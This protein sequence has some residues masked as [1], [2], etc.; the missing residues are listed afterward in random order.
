LTTQVSTENFAANTIVTYSEWSNSLVPKISNVSIAN[1]SYSL[2]DDTAISTNGGY[3]VITGTGF[4]DGATVIINEVTATAVSYINATRLNVQLPAKSAATYDVYVVNPDGATAIG[5]NKI[6]YSAS[7]VWVTDTTLTGQSVDTAFNITFNA[8]GAASY[9]NTTALPAGTT[10]L[11]NGYFYGTV[12]GIVEETTYNF[13]IR[14]TD[15]ENQDSDKNFS[16]TVSVVSVPTSVEYLVVAGGGGGGGAHINQAG[17]AGGG[18]GGYR[19]GTLSIS[20]STPYTVTIGAGGAGGTAT[21]SSSTS[22][23]QGQ[24]SVFSTIT[25]AGGGYGAGG[26]SLGTAGGSGGSGGGGKY[27]SGAAG[28]GNVPSTSPPQGNNGG[29]YATGAPYA[30]GGGGGIGAA[31]SG[32]QGGVGLNWNSLGTYYAGGGSGGSNNET[33]GGLG[34]GGT[35]GGYLQNSGNGATAGGTNTGGGGGGGAN[36]DYPGG[37]VGRAGGSGVVIIRY[38]DAYTD[39]VSTTGSPTYTNT[40]GYKMYKFTGSGSITW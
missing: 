9:S 16:L 5:V 32:V 30:S 21:S 8:T 28:S 35:G 19:T 13:T 26:P 23:T 20:A 10:L 36:N 7:P 3:V 18:A 39:A 29:T 34:G 6:T 14:A 1:S 17:S 11:N 4:E 33:T 24:S 12:T 25:S 31:G 40:G 22:G 37:R 15:G 38:A 2:L 27:S